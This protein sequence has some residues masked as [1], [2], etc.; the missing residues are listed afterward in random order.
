[1]EVPKRSTP[2]P[3]TVTL[4]SCALLWVVHWPTGGNVADFAELFLKSVLQYLEISDVD[5]DFDRYHIIALKAA[6][7]RPE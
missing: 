2:S 6:H 7:E 1:M 3:D 4:D 5:L